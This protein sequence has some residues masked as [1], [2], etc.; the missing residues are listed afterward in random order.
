[1]KKKYLKSGIITDKEVKG[2]F[3]LEAYILSVLAKETCCNKFLVLEKFTTAERD[4]LTGVVAGTAIYNTTTSTIQS[5][6]GTVW[7]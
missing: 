1:M 4:A 3:D 7:A 5:Y 6:N 2:S